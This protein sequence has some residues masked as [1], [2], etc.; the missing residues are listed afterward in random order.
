MV[1]T[2][3]KKTSDVDE[4]FRAYVAQHCLDPDDEQQLIQFFGRFC[5]VICKRG[6]YVVDGEVKSYAFKGKIRMAAGLVVNY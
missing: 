2:R 3:G 4:R 1:R 6:Y 5:A